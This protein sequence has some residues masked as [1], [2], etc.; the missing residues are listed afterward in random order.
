MVRQK[1]TQREKGQP[2]SAQAALPE[3]GMRL[4]AVMIARLYT[5]HMGLGT[6]VHQSP[7]GEASSRAGEN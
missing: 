3:R 4:L 6:S 2:E 7:D 5:R 1:I